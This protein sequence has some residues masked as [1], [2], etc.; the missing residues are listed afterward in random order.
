MEHRCRG[1]SVPKQGGYQA[2]RVPVMWFTALSARPE[3]VQLPAMPVLAARAGDLSAV[4]GVRAPGT[5]DK[6]G[7]QACPGH[8]S[9]GTGCRTGTEIVTKPASARDTPETQLIPECLR[10]SNDG[11]SW[12]LLPRADPR[13]QAAGAGARG[14]CGMRESGVRYGPGARVRGP[15]P[16]HDHH[17]RPSPVARHA[18]GQRRG[19]T[20][21]RR[22]PAAG[23]WRP[24]TGTRRLRSCRTAPAASA[25]G[26]PGARRRPPADRALRLL[27]GED[28]CVRALPAAPGGTTDA[29][30]H[31]RRIS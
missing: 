25:R 15:E 30:Q 28:C 4:P 3:S 1:V 23:G 5:A 18:P 29:M 21:R 16:F 27:G 31:Y 22:R 2:C 24:A 7:R 11:T 19:V 10:D 20:P 26:C 12:L 9:A 17:G 14:S 8:R 13:I 6:C